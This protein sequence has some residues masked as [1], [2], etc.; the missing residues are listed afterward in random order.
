M[1][2]CRRCRPG[3]RA[4]L[5]ACVAT[6]GAEAGCSDVPKVTFANYCEKDVTVDGW[7]VV[8]PAGQV[9]DITEGRPASERITWKYT[10]GSTQKG[11]FIELNTQWPGPGTCFGSHPSYS[12]YNGYNMASKYEALN[13]DTGMPACPDM[14]AEVSYTPEDC[15][16]GPGNG[17]L[18]EGNPDCASDYSEYIKSCSNAINDDGTRS[19]TYKDTTYGA[20]YVNFWCNEAFGF[21][22]LV[23]TLMHCVEHSTPFVLRITT[24]NVNG[25]PSTTTPPTTTSAMTTGASTTGASTGGA[26]TTTVSNSTTAV[27]NVTATTTT[28]PRSGSGFHPEV[29]GGILAVAVVVCAVLGG[30][31]FGIVRQ[32]QL[33]VVDVDD[34]AGHVALAR[35]DGA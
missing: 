28:G 12:T 31:A 9:M 30:A 32:R 14:G 1:R 5:L 10:D 13:P 18:C 16:S 22:E 15:P 24:C 7:N 34:G 35:P 11:D 25:V 26:S 4:A 23:G 21:H 33:A 6:R 3:S 27:P 2:A 20:N 19:P 8:V 29:I 17:Y